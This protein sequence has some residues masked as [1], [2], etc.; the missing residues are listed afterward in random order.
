MSVE[1]GPVPGLFLGQSQGSV[2]PPSSLPAYDWVWPDAVTRCAQAVTADQ[3][4]GVGYQVD[5]RLEY[6]LKSIGPTRWGQLEPEG[7][8][9]K[10]TG[11]T[12]APGTSF[13]VL[14]LGA[15]PAIG[16]GTLPSFAT[17]TRSGQ[18]PRLSVLSAAPAGSIATARFTGG[19]LPTSNFGWRWR[20]VFS[21]ETLSGASL[22]AFYGISPSIS[23]NVPP[24]GLVNCFGVGRDSGDTNLSLYNNDAT[25]GAVKTPLGANFPFNAVPLAYQLDLFTFDGTSYS[26]QLTPVNARLLAI[27]GVVTTRLPAV[28]IRPN[29]MMYV[30]NN[31]DA[32]A[33]ALGVASVEFWP[34]LQG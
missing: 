24:N 13:S 11:L 23:T 31:A 16:T 17:L 33:C 22:R 3:I 25:V 8:E 6:K 29:W 32:A 4:G 34:M 18:L 20:M 21:L 7:T 26:W 30:S 9:A 5:M 10:Q 12:A 1:A 28:A 19:T 14:G 2:F 27:S 15:T